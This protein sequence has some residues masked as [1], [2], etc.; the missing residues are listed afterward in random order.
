MSG[1]Y[2][3]SPGDSSPQL[4]PGTDGIGQSDMAVSFTGDATTLVFQS[5]E[6]QGIVTAEVNRASQIV[7]KL[8]VPPGA[9]PYLTV[10]SGDG[11]WIAALQDSGGKTQN[12]VPVFQVIVFPR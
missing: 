8:P 4:V 6:G 12:G 3:Y 5:L 9:S 2:V 7:R 1:I 10:V 11:R